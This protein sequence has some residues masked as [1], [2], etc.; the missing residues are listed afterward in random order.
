MIAL[1]QFGLLWVFQNPTGGEDQIWR[2]IAS[3]EASIHETVKENQSHFVISKSDPIRGYY[4]E[5]RGVFLL[6]PIRYLLNQGL[7]QPATL[8]KESAG[9]LGKP[10]NLKRVD[11]Q[12]RYDE[13][14]A[15]LRKHELTK[16]ANFN[17]AV[18]NLKTA[19]PR[20]LEI[21]ASLP[22]DES[23]TI[24]VEERVAW[25]YPG[26]SA[27]RSPTIKV[28]TLTVDK[29]LVSDVHEGQTTLKKDWLKQVKSKTTNRVY[30]SFVP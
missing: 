6:V 3:L 29:N 27:E 24:V 20:V 22:V 25:Y 21:L 9:N 28:V 17:K 30:Y 23:L 1:I 5:R 8:S 2:E 14:R 16:E 10:A 18:N 7:Q 12:K 19:I 4:V 11:I 15:H 26:F 13:W